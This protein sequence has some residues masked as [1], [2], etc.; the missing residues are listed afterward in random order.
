MRPIPDR[1]LGHLEASYHSAAG[2]IK[3]SWKYKGNKWT[4]TF[5]IP[6]GAS[7]TVTLPGEENGREYP[8]GTYTLSKSM[9]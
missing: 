8:S 9:N 2:L 3:S 7:A 5:T 4:W 6:K 1:R